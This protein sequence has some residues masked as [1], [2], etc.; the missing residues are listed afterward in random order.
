MRALLIVVASLITVIFALLVGPYVVPATKFK[1]EILDD[2]SK[3]TQGDVF[4]ESFR[5]TVLPYPAFTIKDLNVT[6]LEQDFRGQS[7]LKARE[8]EGSLSPGALLKG[9]IITDVTLKEAVI[10]LEFSNDGKSNIKPPV[11]EDSKNKIRSLRVEDGKLNLVWADRKPIIIDN[12]KF[13]AADIK[14]EPALKG[15]IRLKGTLKNIGQEVDVAGLFSVDFKDKI[16]KAKQVAVFVKDVRYNIDATLLYG[17]KPKSF[18][19]HVVCPNLTVDALSSIWPKIKSGLPFG[20]T[21]DGSLVTD[22]EFKGTSDNIAFKIHADATAS[23][24]KWGHLFFKDKNKPLKFILDGNYQPTHVTIESATFLIGD[25]SFKINGSVVRQPN[26]PSRLILETTN[27]KGD[28]V[29]SLLPFLTAIKEMENPSISLEVRGPLLSEKER[30]INGH[31][32]ASQVKMYGRS[33]LD[34]KTDFQYTPDVF[35][36]NAIRAKFYDGSLSGNGTIILGDVPHYTFSMV[37]GDIDC[38]KM[39]APTPI[40]KGMGSLV[41]KGEAKKHPLAEGTLILKQGDIPPLKI[42]KNIFTSK[43]WDI[44]K[45]HVPKGLN[46]VQIEK[47]GELKGEVNNLKASFE[48]RDGYLLINKLDWSDPKYKAL[49][50]VYVDPQDVITGEGNIYLSRGETLKLITDPVAR[51]EVMESNGTLDIPVAVSGRLTEV[52]IRPAETRFSNNLKGIATPSAFVFPTQKKKEAK[53]LKP[54]AL[55]GVRPA[56]LA[57]LIIP[58]KV[59]PPAAAALSA[60]AVKMPEVKPEELPPPKEVEKEKQPVVKKKAT[61]KKMATK[62]AKKKGRRRKVSPK[63]KMKTGVDDDVFKVIVGD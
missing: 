31:L 27:F 37:V 29:L 16:F 32:S 1:K 57:P 5:F 50:K 11:L 60:P 19:F 33:F 58:K 61:K 43:T 35:I 7:V 15:K 59:T 51:K 40:I 3:I 28:Q 26:Y 8:V 44:L 23:R 21:I 6:S 63:T 20:L 17:Q 9:R 25:N 52:N 54:A 10:N 42:G 53:A 24:V 36:L 38:S 18:G 41:F 2:L 13:T 4:V 39:L 22:I 30:V 14:A 48:L 56:P 46:E 62:P 12:L 45:L 47:L 34:L 49:L 55:P